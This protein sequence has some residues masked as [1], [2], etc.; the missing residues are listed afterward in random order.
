MGNVSCKTLK[1]FPEAS[2]A[3]LNYLHDS[4]LTD[5]LLPILRGE[6]VLQLP[7]LN[8]NHEGLC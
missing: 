8:N 5:G 4:Q 6:P 2:D 7:P 3:T 1:P